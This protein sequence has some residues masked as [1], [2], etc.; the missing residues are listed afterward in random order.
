MTCVPPHIS[1]LDETLSNHKGFTPK[2]EEFVIHYC[3]N[4]SNLKHTVTSS[5]LSARFTIENDLL[6]FVQPLSIILTLIS[7]ATII[8]TVVLMG[9][10][11]GRR[12]G[13]A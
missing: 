1:S 11:T 10:K 7:S 3:S 9:K 2:I 8:P 12:V 13:G 6:P 5:N 4:K